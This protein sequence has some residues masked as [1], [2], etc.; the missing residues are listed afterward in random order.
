MRR[1]VGIAG[2]M[3]SGKDT[4][5]EMLVHH[6]TDHEALYFDHW[7]QT[8]FAKMLKNICAQ[9][10]EFSQD[11]LY[12]DAKNEPD[13]RYRRPDGTFLTPREAMQKL[14]TEWG[15]ACWPDIWAKRTIDEAKLYPCN[16]VITDCRFVSEAKMIRAA[17]GEVWRV[18]R[19]E[20][21]EV[22]ATHQ[23]EV[24]IDTHEFKLQVDRKIRNIGSLLDLR[25]KVER[26]LRNECPECGGSA[27]TG[28]LPG[29]L[30]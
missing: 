18:Y 17:G 13:H 29:C 6:F 30:K 7:T 3:R 24:E 14:G 15:R 5:G 12:G 8:S 16:V 22:L 10:F 21:D 1:L 19:P 9:V 2:R 26:V 28:H 20:A 23:S 25:M 27:V 11:Q 4:I